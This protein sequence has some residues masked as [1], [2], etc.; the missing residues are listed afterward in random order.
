MIARGF[1]FAALLGVGLVAQ[2]G[3]QEGAQAELVLGSGEH[4]YDW[5]D[6]WPKPDAEGAPLE[7]GYTHGC[8]VVDG[9]DNV[10]VETNAEQAVF[11]FDADGALLRTFEGRGLED[12]LHGLCLVREGDDEFLYATHLKGR[13]LK[14]DLTGE[15]VWEVGY[16]EESGLYP[17]GERFHP[18]GVAVASNGDVFV[19]DGYGRH[20]VHRFDRDGKY[21]ASFGGTGTALGEFK[22]PHGI[23]IETLFGRE[24]L[25]V[26]DRE[27]RRLQ[28]LTLEG[29]PVR[30]MTDG[31]RRP[32]GTASKDGVWAV[33]DIEG[34]VTLLDE[35][36]AVLAHLGEQPDPEKADTKDV[37]PAEQERGRFHSPHAVA[38]DS[39]G[40]LYVVDWLVAGRVTKLR[41]R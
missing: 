23:R 18:T 1:A 40:A 17:G 21:L 38:F 35:K 19:A 7:L 33:A 15:I 16:P 37:P 20:Y 3:A 12:G 36:G 27:N 4:A 24:L 2:K 25:L 31:I 41:P 32:C 5:V 11:V 14:L 28:L 10:Y 22:N 6:G 26:A 13:V 8:V 34:R 30:A 39:R 9:D 29:K